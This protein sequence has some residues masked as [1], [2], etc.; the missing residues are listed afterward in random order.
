MELFK[1]E[2]S[3]LLPLLSVLAQ[4][5]ICQAGAAASFLLVLCF[6]VPL[7][8]NGYKIA[9]TGEEELRHSS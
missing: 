3:T 9:Q 5:V 7:L 2:Q 6:L 8:G 1:P 4:S